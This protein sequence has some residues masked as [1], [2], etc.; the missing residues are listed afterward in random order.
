VA[1]VAG[2]HHEAALRGQLVLLEDEVNPALTAALD[3]GLQV[4][5]LGSSLLF[6]TPRLMMLDVD[7][8]GTFHRLAAA[9][10]RALDEI[11]RV[12]TNK[13]TV[14]RAAPGADRCQLHRSGTS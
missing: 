7:G 2:T 13:A 9:F 14:G 5:G 12:R 6:E 4:V 11:R 1:F 8:S 10:R 3:G